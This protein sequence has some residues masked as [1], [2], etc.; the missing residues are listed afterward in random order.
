MRRHGTGGTG[1]VRLSQRTSGVSA[2]VE[3]KVFSN[4]SGTDEVYVRINCEMDYQWRGVDQ[5]CE[6]PW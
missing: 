5:D 2:S 1:S 6:V 4:G 3:R